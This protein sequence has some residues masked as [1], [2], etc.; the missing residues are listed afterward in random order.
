MIRRITLEN[1]MSHVLTV[2][3]PADGLTVLCGPNNCG[4]SAVVSAIQTVCGEN[5]GDF[6][7][8]HGEKT[9]RVTIETDDGHTITWQRKGKAPSYVINGRDVHRIGRGNLPDDLHELL[10]LPPVEAGEGK[11]RF[12]IHFGFQKEPIFLLGS[13]SDTAAFFSTSAEAERL[14]EM[15]KRHKAKWQANRAEHRT[16]E[17][18]VKR[19]D[20]RLAALSPLE[21]IAPQVEAIE[22]EHAGLLLADHDLRVLAQ[23]IEAMEA[24]QSRLNRLAAEVEALAGL[25]APPALGDP[26]PLEQMIGRIGKCRDEGERQSAMHDAVASL[27]PPPAQ[28]DCLPLQQLA[29]AIER[30]SRDATVWRARAGASE[31]LREPPTFGDA[32]RLAAT[33]DRFEAVARQSRAERA[34]ESVLSV[35]EEPPIPVD[36]R[37]ISETGKKLKALTAM[38]AAAEARAAALV[39]LI[40]PPALIDLSNLLSAVARFDRTAGEV[41]R[42]RTNVSTA[43]A[44]VTAVERQIVD[45]VTANPICPT[46]G[47]AMDAEHL[48]HEGGSHVG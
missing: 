24:A 16:A 6:M 4:K 3:E 43:D 18:D 23:R 2:I 32:E 13:D 42:C 9:A 7:V 27:A 10:K 44:G 21:Q 34:R 12:H 45:F 35:M 25:A 48:I 38:V 26:L 8:R 20:E 22:T 29:V 5:D 47:S 19:L 14:L 39:P 15:Q 46:C 11:K 31:A 33:C 28:H 1:Y 30:T 41:Q 36:L 17:A 37:P 40:E